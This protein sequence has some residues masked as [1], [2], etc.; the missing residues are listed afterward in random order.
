VARPSR[1]GGQNWRSG[2]TRGPAEFSYH[3]PHGRGVALLELLPDTPS[4]ARHAVPP[5]SV[6]RWYAGRGGL[7]YSGCAGSLA[8]DN[9][10]RPCTGSLFS[11]GATWLFLL[12]VLF[13]SAACALARARRLSPSSHSPR[14]GEVTGVARGGGVY[15]YRLHNLPLFIPRPAHGPRVPERARASSA[16]VAHAVGS[17]VRQRSERFGWGVAGLTVL[18]RARRRRSARPCRFSSSSSGAPPLARRRLPAGVFLVVAGAR[19]VRDLD[20]YLAP[21]RSSCQASASPTATPPSGVASGYVFLRRRGVAA[22]G[23]GSSTP[24][25]RF[26]TR[27]SRGRS[28]GRLPQFETTGSSRP[29]MISCVG[30]VRHTIFRPA[31]KTVTI[32]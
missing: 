24:P 29:G 22:G 18:P 13:A 12:L 9:A 8:V 28:F 2:S 30:R 5:V 20:R 4:L 16:V 21:G 7:P 17:S 26:E 14:P 15:R 31:R 10:G 19:A 11:V 1:Q 3:D 32:P 23:R 6:P 25:G 27:S